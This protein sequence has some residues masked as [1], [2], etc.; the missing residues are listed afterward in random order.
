MIKLDEQLIVSLRPKFSEQDIEQMKLYF[1]VSEKYNEIMSDWFNEKL[2]PHPVFGPIIAMQTPEMQKARNEMS[3]LLTKKAIYNGEWDAYNSDLILQGVMYAKM[4][5]TFRSWYEVV[6]MVKDYILPHILTYFRNDQTRILGAVT[7][8]S[9]LTD[10]AMQS[11]AE[12]FFIEKR[13]I[14]EE[15]QVKQAALIRELESFAYVV[16]HDLKS[17]LRGIAKLSEW[18]VTDHGES[19]GDDGRQKLDLLRSRV[20]RL[21]NL[22]EGILDYSR[23]GRSESV[24]EQIDVKEML[25][26]VIDLHS[27][28][29]K[30]HFS[31]PENLPTITFVRSQLAQVFSNLISNA[32]KHN[33]KDR[34][35]IAIGFEEKA[36]RYEF[37]V[38]DN[39]PGIEPEYHEK[40]FAIFQTLQTKDEVESTGI[41]LSIVKKIVLDAGG[42]IS[43]R[44]ELGK[45]ASFVFT[46]PKK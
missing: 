22:I 25:A 38:T 8:L 6:A 37:T 36:D 42:E 15:Q 31:V 28:S 41:G 20:Y 45:G 23:L 13:K 44:S 9:K 2:K 40:V 1:E 24:K 19:L 12:A 34:T 29:K 46:L 16:S 39:G 17:P 18:L 4:G 26:E 14:I 35:E 11:I 33:D 43:I 32:I 5:M 27:S 10:F 30:V 7:G 21:D 3:Q